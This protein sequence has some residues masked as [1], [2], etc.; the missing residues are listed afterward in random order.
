MA[1]GRF[2]EVAVTVPVDGTFTYG[3]PEH[4]AGVPLARGQRVLV[5]FGGRRLTGIVIEPEGATPEGYEA[6]DLLEI[7]DLEPLLSEE[8]ISLCVF[9][10][11]YYLHPLGDVLRTALPPGMAL[12]GSRFLVPSSPAPEEAPA[13]GKAAEEVLARLREAPAGRLRVGGRG[14]VP[15][16]VAARLLEAGVAEVRESWE[17]VREGRRAVPVTVRQ[18]HSLD[19]ARLELERA[20]AQ[21]AVM[22]W[23]E[24]R[25]EASRQ[26]LMAAVPGAGPLLK[27]LEERGLVA[28][29]E[30]PESG[31][32]VAVEADPGR[33]GELTPEQGPVVEALV[34]SLGAFSA[35]LI[36]GVTGSGKTEIY[37]RLIDA[38]LE[39]GLGALVLVPEIALTP[40]LVGR[41]QARFG[42]TVALL[43]SGLSDAERRESWWRLHR[44]EARIAVG[45][46]SAIYAPVERLGVVVV[47]EEHDGSFKQEEGLCYSARDLAVVRARQSDALLVLGSATPSLESLANVERGRYAHHRLLERVAR[48]SLPEVQV[49]DLR[50]QRPAS[51]E[52]G[53]REEVLPLLTGTLIGALEETLGAGQQAIL[54]LNRRGQAPA[55]LC[56]SCGETRRCPNCDISL[57][58][59]RSPPVV[60]CHYCGHD[61][62]IPRHC[63]GCGG[64]LQ[65][66]GA[67]TQALE[68]EVLRRFPGVRVLR[69]DRDATR[70]RGAL[71]E[72]LAGFASGHFDVMVGTQMVA[73]GHDFPGVTLVGVVLADQ[74]L[75]IPDLRAAERAVQLLSQVAGR[76]G[77]GEDPGRVI[78]QSWQPDHPAI[79]AALAGDYAGFA[80]REL[81]TREEM[82]W[83]PYCRL[84]LVRFDGGSPRK[85]ELAALAAGRAAEIAAMESPEADLEI[86]GPAPAPLSRLRN[87]A[88]WQLLVKAGSPAAVRWL[89]GYLASLPPRSGV[90][91]SLDVDPGNML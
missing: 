89:G 20:P 80:R 73:K 65:A 2:V 13:L 15:T 1:A 10:A 24:A 85:V 9:A 56:P 72:G 58:L 79:Q 43:H 70:Q 34:A 50:Q 68:H 6:R 8:L 33:P 77:R 53:G 45:V 87:K 30:A 78:L 47:D 62:E 88:R 36:E 64:E 86:L 31:G 67:G 16:P 76:A 27:K 55:L 84:L 32:G 11:D 75:W 41:F 25:G 44:G 37:L 90:R 18:L 63:E 22:E 60:L 17:G 35:H 81:V 7:L 52:G 42:P 46:R 66:A 74:G 51:F 82:R 21:R 26:E 83:P 54:F 23:L 4:L 19:D 49:V 71:A 3:V 57:T 29:E 14:G 40:Q 38:A 61:A 48:R 39:R 12:R 91:M 59:H 69:L 5:P 28:L